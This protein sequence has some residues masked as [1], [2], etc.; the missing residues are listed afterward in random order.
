MLAAA[1]L[2]G[3]RVVYRETGDQISAAGSVLSHPNLCEER[4]DL[5]REKMEVPSGHAEGDRMTDLVRLT[6]RTQREIKSM[7]ATGLNFE[8]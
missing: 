7:G 1:N 6:G 8:S 3:E 5:T 2:V 4:S